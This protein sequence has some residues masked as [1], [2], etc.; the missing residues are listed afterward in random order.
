MYFNISED[1]DLAKLKRTEPKRF[2]SEANGAQYIDLRALPLAP[3]PNFEIGRLT[4]LANIL[5]G[6]IFA[7]VEAAQSGHPGGS[8]SKVEQFLTLLMGGFIAFDPTDPKHPGRDRVIWSSGHCTPL[9]YSGLALIYEVMRRRGRQFSEAVVRPVFPEDLIRFRH[10]DGP[11]GHA[12]SY[13]PLSDFTTGPSGHGFSAAGGMALV[14]K[15]CGLPTKVWVFMGDAESEEGLTYEARNI[16]AAT[17]ADNMIVALDYNHFGIDGDINEVIS[18]PYANYWHGLGW[19]VIEADGHN[20]LELFYAYKLAAKGL[21]NNLPTVVISHTVKGKSYGKMENSSASH[22]SHLPHGEYLQVIKKLGFNIPGDEK[23]IMEDIEAIMETITGADELYIERALQLCAEKIIHEPEQMEKMQTIL[24]GRPLTQPTKILRPKQ[25]PPELLF[26]EG[27]QVS[28][29]KAAGAW[30]KWLMGQTAFFYTGAGDLSGSTD[31]KAAEQVYG[32]INKNNP[33][34]RGIRFGIAEQ[35][36]AMMAS[37]LTEDILPGGFK[38]ISAFASYAVF[39][40]MMA[41]GVRLSLVGNFVNPQTA[42]FF[43]MVASHDGPETGEDGP[44]HHGM[45]WMALYDAFP[46][47]KVYKPLDANETVEMLFHA[48][49]TGEP[50]ALSLTRADVPV[51]AR[52]GGV[53]PASAANNGAYVYKNYSGNGKNK[54]AIA[55][56]GGKMLANLA[57][58]MPQIENNFDIKI[59]AVTSPELFVEHRKHDPES[60]RAILSDEE[61]KKLIVLHN[62]WKGFLYPFILPADYENRVLGMDGY[63][64]SGRPDEIYEQAGFSPPQLLE[65]IMLA[66]GKIVV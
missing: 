65:K 49:K 18:M 4:H 63:Y 24:A 44:T 13:T 15:S 62:G 43:I 12:E 3:V 20:P 28:T 32:L 52:S 48:L 25:L 22:G 8:S 58:I 27:E 60:A 5:R 35:N 56:C 30:F 29:R 51:I 40:N 26:K 7:T 14:H 41:N 2:K 33:L 54:I 37:G 38:P 10:T 64:K 17:G 50:I 42:G 19:N 16:L 36:M 9:L 1:G 59:I 45:Y 53:P 6:L 31:V 47:I 57:G 46:G 34:G 66:A 21:D 39:T 23:N 61:R 11:Q 55:V